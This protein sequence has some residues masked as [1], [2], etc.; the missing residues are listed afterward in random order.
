MNT[1]HVECVL[2]VAGIDIPDARQLV[3]TYCGVPDAAGRRSHWAYAYFDAVDND[4][5]DVAP[6]D[7][8]ACAA[9]H[10]RFSQPALE[11]FIRSRRRLQRIL[12]EIP[13]DLDLSDADDRVLARLEAIVAGLAEGDGEYGPALPDAGRALVTKVLHRKRPRLVPMFDKAIADRY[14]RALP[15]RRAI[16]GPLFARLIR[17]DMADADNRVALAAISASL[18]RSLADDPVPSDLR[19]LDITVW[20]DDHR[21]RMQEAAAREER[22]SR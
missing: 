6:Q 16:R 11:S 8:T 13:A 10:A 18:A 4:P 1:S 2:R 21:D 19:L 5:D 20:M 15:D 9:L 22:S 17:D 14:S 3:E 7:V 12:T